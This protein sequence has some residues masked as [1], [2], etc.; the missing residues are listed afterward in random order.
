E[1]EIRV[2]AGSIIAPEGSAVFDI[3]GRRVNAT[4][5]RAGI[6]IVRTAG[7]KAVKVKVD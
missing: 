6:Y 5:L 4:G 7:G 2:E 3:T 1:D